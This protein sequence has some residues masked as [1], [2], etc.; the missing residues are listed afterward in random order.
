MHRAGE[1]D[2]PPMSLALVLLW[3]WFVRRDLPLGE[4]PPVDCRHVDVGSF[5][6]VPVLPPLAVAPRAWVVTSPTLFPASQSEA[7]GRP[8]DARLVGQAFEPPGWGR[9]LRA[10]TSVCGVE[11]CGAPL[12]MHKGSGPVGLGRAGHL[13]GRGPPWVLC[14]RDSP[15]L[16]LSNRWVWGWGRS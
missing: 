1:V 5:L 15:L 2:V 16:L 6:V 7:G 4:P 3:A 12:G 8:F 14:S 10:L 9:F 13:Y 11:G